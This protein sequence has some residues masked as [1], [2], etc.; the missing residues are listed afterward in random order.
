MKPIAV[1]LL[2][3]A[4][5]AA[6]QA[7]ATADDTDT[8]ASPITLASQFFDH[9][10]VNYFVFANGI[11]DTTVPIL[12]GSQ[13]VTG[14]SFGWD[15]GGGITASHELHDGDFSVSYR[16][17]YRSYVD[18]AYSAGTNQ[19]LLLSFNKRLSRHWSFFTTQ[20]AGILQYGGGSYSVAPAAIGSIAP[21]PFSSSARFV[22]SSLSLA[23]QQTR[24]LSYI[25]TGNFYLNNYNYGGAISSIGGSGSASIQYRLT[26][27]TSV[28]GTYSRTYYTYNKGVGQTTLDGYSL[29]LAHQFANHWD[30]SLSAG[31]NRSHTSG[32]I[33]IPIALILGQQLVTG[34]EVGAYDRVSY[35]PSVQGTVTHYLRHSSVSFSGG[36]GVV[37]GNGTFLTSRDQFANGTYSY[38]TRHSNISFGGG[39][40]RLESIA[41]NISQSYSS[42]NLSISYG[43]TLRRFLAANVRY[44]YLRYGGLFSYGGLNESRF[45]FGLSLSSKSVPITLY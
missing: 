2:V 31:V 8:H 20:A 42:S 24:R 37:P 33:S 6:Q 12:Q 16:G 43:H 26:A 27:R 39:F 44:D 11:Y 40:F 10:F 29:T 30:A 15:V 4:A 17:D 7:P 28:A 5:V 22:D 19:S 13:T 9:D 3:S 32:V 38:S 35:T 18:S 34:Y 1:L 25:F 14:G 23:Y 36:Q 45:T 21:N 41:N